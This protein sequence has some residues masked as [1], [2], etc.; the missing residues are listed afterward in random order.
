[1]SLDSFQM[2]AYS[3]GGA[4]KEETINKT[5]RPLKAIR[6]FLIKLKE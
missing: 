6:G 2:I 1:M 3:N 4:D 5:Y